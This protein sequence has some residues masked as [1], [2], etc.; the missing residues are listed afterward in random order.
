MQNSKAKVLVIDDDPR[1]RN[2]LI[3][4]LS[5]E[6]YIA[7]PAE[8]GASALDMIKN[9]GINLVLLDLMLPD[10]SGIEVLKQLKEIKPALPVIMISGLAQI[11]DAVEATREGA[12]DF[13]EKSSFDKDKFLTII[14][15]ALEKERLEKEI[16]LL[17][18][19]ILKRYQMIGISKEMSK[20]FDLVEKAAPT[21][22][23]IL[24]TGESGV[25]K[26][27]VAR[28]IHI[29]SERKDNPFVKINC[30]AMPDTL[31]ESELFGYEKGAFT[32]AKNQKQGKLEIADNGTLFLD[33]IADMSLSAQ[34]KLLRFLQEGEFERLGSTKTIKVDVRVIAATNKNLEKEIS[35]KKFRDD[36]LYRLNVIKI[37]VPPL[38]ERKDD[39]AELAMY[40]LKSACEENGV[41]LKILS[42][43]AVSFL[44]NQYWKGNIRELK[45]AMERTSILIKINEVDSDDLKKVIEITNDELEIIEKPLRDARDD[46]EKEY[47]YKILKRNNWNLT[48]TAQVLDIDRTHLYRVMKQLGIK[49]T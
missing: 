13:L 35:E 30:A 31:L 11:K 49:E 44:E 27:L 7:F 29:R 20:V 45:N 22:A 17:K 4:I 39:I 3:S 8:D 5:Q 1:A 14:R 2:T 28:A 43:D 38:R 21:K 18:E 33:E 10:M 15:N 46:F 37:N 23:S 16:I 40:F 32:D 36:L 26:E 25:G 47:I 12:Y 48:K 42:K 24:I 19:E 6:G 41:A 34:A 9:N